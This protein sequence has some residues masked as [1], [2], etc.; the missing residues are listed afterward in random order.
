MQLHSTGNMRWSLP[1]FI[2]HFISLNLLS[3]GRL[4]KKKSPN[5]NSGWIINNFK[6]LL[7]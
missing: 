4:V 7:Y 3:Y 2:S 1:P 6:I 5:V